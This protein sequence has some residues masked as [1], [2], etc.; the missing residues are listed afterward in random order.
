M[1][2]QNDELV[3]G[4]DFI[5]TVDAS[6]DG[7]TD[8]SGYTTEASLLDKDR[9]S[10]IDFTVQTETADWATGIIR[11]KFVRAGDATLIAAGT[12]YL[13]VRVTSPQ[14]EM[15]SLTPFPEVVVIQGSTVVSP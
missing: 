3:S 12:Y 2:K 6:L 5:I 13:E 4:N 8:F 9:A 11:V 10:I 7:N 14:N 15:V 1:T